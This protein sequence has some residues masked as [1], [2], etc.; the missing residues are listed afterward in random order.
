LLTVSEI[1]DGI[2][3]AN[4]RTRF[5]D[6]QDGSS[7]TILVGERSGDLF[8]SSWLGV[9]DGSKYTGW[10]VVGWTGEPPKN[11][12]FSSVHFHGFAQFNSMHPGITNF[13]FVDG[14]TR[15]ITDAIDPVVF[16]ALGTIRGGEIV[17][18]Y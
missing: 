3:Y 10:R 4:S 13:S 1:I 2:F 16:R 9:V 8:D 5:A 12:G 17:N 18:D 11:K 15:T 14:A 6:I 7:N